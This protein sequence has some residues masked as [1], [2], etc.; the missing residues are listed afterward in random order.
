M[1]STETLPW[2]DQPTNLGMLGLQGP[3]V[4]FQVSIDLPAG[5]ALI[6]A[7]RQGEAQGK[8]GQFLE[9]PEEEN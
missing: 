9:Q 3:D 4:C 1:G 6:T 7:Q 8:A 5:R 2:Q